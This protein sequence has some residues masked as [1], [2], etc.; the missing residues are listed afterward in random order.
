MCYGTINSQ[1]I[2]GCDCP[3]PITEY[4]FQKKRYNEVLEE[5]NK[6]IK[7]MDSELNHLRKVIISLTK[8]REV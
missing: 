1:N 5:K 7:Q 4:S 8:P 2:S 6:V 3:E